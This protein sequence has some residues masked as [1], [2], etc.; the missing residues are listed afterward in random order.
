MKKGKMANS[1]V[2]AL[3]NKTK[4]KGLKEGDSYNL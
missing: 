4:M 2:I 1:D 3:Q